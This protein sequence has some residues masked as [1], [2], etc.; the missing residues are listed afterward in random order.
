MDFRRE[1]WLGGI[2]VALYLFGFLPRIGFIFRISGI[3]LLLISLRQLATK[4]LE[5]KIFT[6]FLTGFIISV[7]GVGLAIFTAILTGAGAF[8]RYY[9]EGSFSYQLGALSGLGTT[10]AVFLIILYLSLVAGSYFYKG[11]FTALAIKSGINGFKTGG[12]LLFYGAISIV[13][14]VGALVMLAGWIVMLVSFFSL[15]DTLETQ[16]PSDSSSST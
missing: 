9:V 4:F 1:K 6:N 10:L 2:G 16:Q 14:I 3:V 12:E 7:A 8:I 15:P 5:D 11:S 13:L